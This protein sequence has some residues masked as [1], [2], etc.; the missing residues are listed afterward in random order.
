MLGLLICKN[1]HE[2]LYESISELG[3]L[4]IDLLWLVVRKTHFTNLSCFQ[5]GW[6]IAKNAPLSQWTSRWGCWV[7]LGSRLGR[8]Q[9]NILFLFTKWWLILHNVFNVTIRVNLYLLQRLARLDLVDAS[10][11]IGHYITM[12][13]MFMA[14]S[15]FG[16][17]MLG[18]G[19]YGLWKLL[20]IKWVIIMT[21]LLLNWLAFRA[22]NLDFNVTFLRDHHIDTIRAFCLFILFGLART[23][24]RK[25]DRIVAC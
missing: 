21:R 19:A 6:I 15:L 22:Q 14:W 12:L 5:L 10:R 1:H 20:W 7:Y 18:I 23:E 13:G 16:V 2:W 3:L 8:L 11:P 25:Y 9:V 17:L 4:F 24:S